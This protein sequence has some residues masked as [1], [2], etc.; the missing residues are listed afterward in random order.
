MT[1]VFIYLNKFTSVSSIVS[2]FIIQEFLGLIFLLLNYRVFQFFILVFKVGMA[3]FHFW[4]FSVLSSSRGYV[5]LWFLTFQKLPFIPVLLYFLNSRY[6]YFLI[7]GIFFCYF[8][9]FITKSYKSM[10]IISST[11]SFN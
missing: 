2:Y 5:V 6:F 8:Q 1:L 3:P 9:I 7:I 10:L 11:E 4:I